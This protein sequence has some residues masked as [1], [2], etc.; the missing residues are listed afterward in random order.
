VAETSGGRQSL[1]GMYPTSRRISRPSDR[2]SIPK[3]WARPDVGGSRPSRILISVDFPAP[4]APTRPTTP[5]GISTVSRA[6]AV[7]GP[8]VRVSESVAMAG[9]SGKVAPAELPSAV[10]SPASMVLIVVPWLS[11]RYPVFP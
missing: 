2:Q 1:S 10:R 3:I 8:K 7:T 4:L 9:T 11:R 5:V 6:N